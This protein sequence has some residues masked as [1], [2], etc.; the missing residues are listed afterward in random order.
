MPFE[1]VIV[2][3]ATATRARTATYGGYML[4]MMTLCINYKAQLAVTN[5]GPS[6]AHH[7]SCS[8]RVG[9]RAY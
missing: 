2:A 5:F 8:Y 6:Q 3:S 7:T 1:I 9:Q 4:M